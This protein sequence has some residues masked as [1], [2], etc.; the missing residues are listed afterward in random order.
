MIREQQ[1]HEAREASPQVDVRLDSDSLTEPLARIPEE[2]PCFVI[3]SIQLVGPQS[4]RFQ[5]LLDRFSPVE[6]NG[7]SSR[8][9]PIR[10]QAVEPVLG[11]CLG[12]QGINYVM[13]V[14]QNQL[15][16][17]GYIT[18]RIVVGAQDVTT[19]TL[20][21]TL[22]P[23]VIGKIHFSDQQSRNAVL[24]MKSGDLLNLRDIEQALESMKRLPSV[25]ADIQIIPARGEEALSGESDLRIEWTQ[26]SPV[27][28]V[29]TA[30]NSGTENTGIYQGGI[31]LAYDNMLGLH[32]ILNLSYSHDIGGAE[33]LKG[34]TESYSLDYSFPMGYWSMALNVNANQYV[35]TVQGP[36][37]QYQYRGD[38]RTA[39][40]ELSRLIYRDS[41]RKITT[42]LGTWFRHSKNFIDDT[43][44]VPQRRRTA[45]IDLRLDYRQFIGKA[46]LDGGVNYR[47][48]TGMFDAQPALEEA[49]GEGTSRPTIIKTNLQ[50]SLPFQL[51]QQRL[52]YTGSWRRQYNRDPLTPQDRFSI[53]GRY[54]VRGFD[55]ES[56]LSADRGWLIRNDLALFLGS[57]KQSVYIGA[58]YG[59]VNGFPEQFL[60]GD[61]LAGAV[62]GVKGQFWG[63]HYDLSVGTPINK[64]DGFITG[65]GAVYLQINR[66]F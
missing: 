39:S 44:L 56:T 29:L 10:D 11:R 15:V 65:H 47:K 28:V 60:L 48:G 62:L 41:T 59:Q 49:F 18:S 4:Q 30:D 55:G 63:N 61:H 21:L 34:G 24:P 1:R 3:D 33:P 35:Q 66:A 51:G 36:F 64:P 9:Q 31:S 19:G 43:E 13:S 22:I 2:T 20:V 8:D 46:I 5:W 57:G 40:W 17:H 50:L 53:G 38:S 45:G 7:T 12:T 6:V 58:D 37:Q 32:D 42:G 25:E 54:T 52:H 23:G 26:D 16:K 27:R 14:L